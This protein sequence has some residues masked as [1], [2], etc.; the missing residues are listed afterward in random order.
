MYRKFG[1]FRYRCIWTA[2]ENTKNDQTA[3][4]LVAYRGPLRLNFCLLENRMELILNKAINSSKYFDISAQLIN[5]AMLGTREK[6][7]IPYKVNTTAN[8]TKYCEHI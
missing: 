2:F 3:G 6:L 1:L 4:V 5:N 7:I 8:I